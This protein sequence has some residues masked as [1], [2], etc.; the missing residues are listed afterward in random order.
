MK[1]NVKFSKF[2]ILLTTV[3]T[4]VLFVGCV[5]TFDEKPTFYAIVF[6]LA[7]L[8]L[9]SAL[10]APVSVS[11]SDE[12]VVIKSLLKKHKIP[13]SKIKDI[14]LFQPT[15]GAI[16]ICA[17]GGYFG[18]WGLFCEKDIGRYIAFYGKASDCFLI[19]LHDGGKRVIGCKNPDVMCDYIKRRL[20]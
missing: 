7:V 1:S 18:Y 12:S 19:E 5:L 9:T 20:I 8:L 11:V 4:G 10:Y 15:M 3:I 14:E 13:L 6:I 2:S 17:S 16:R